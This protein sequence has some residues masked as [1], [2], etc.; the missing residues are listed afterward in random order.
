[1][2]LPYLSGERTP[3]PDPLARGA[4]V[5]LTVRHEL[6]H[7][8]RSVMEGVSFGLRDSAELIKSSVELGEVRVAG[9]GASSEAWLQIIADVMNLP[10]RV[11]GTPEGA[12][13]G[14]ALLAATGT[15]AFGSVAEATEATVRVGDPVEPSPATD[16]YEQA[17]GLYRSLYPALQESFQAASRL[18]T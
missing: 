6:A 18:D 5:G 14:A 3:H 9:G 13:Y 12:A 15:G 1:M 16:V 10:V 7:L 4:F 2:F 11:V 8:T 17:Y